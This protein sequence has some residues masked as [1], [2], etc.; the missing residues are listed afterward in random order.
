MRAIVTERVGIPARLF[1]CLRCGT[2]LFARSN[3]VENTPRQAAP[4][5]V[6]KGRSAPATEWGRAFHV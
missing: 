6:E 1:F 5:A 3:Q 4:G 2:D